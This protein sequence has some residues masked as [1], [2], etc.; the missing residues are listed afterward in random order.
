MTA[1]LC[2]H[3]YFHTRTFQYTFHWCLDGVTAACMHFVNRAVPVRFR[4]MAPT[5]RMMK[6][7]RNFSP[8]NDEPGKHQV[9]KTGRATC[10]SCSFFA[11]P[12]CAKLWLWMPVDRDHSS[13]P[14]IPGVQGT[15][16][17]YFLQVTKRA[18]L[19]QLNRTVRNG[20]TSVSP[21]LFPQTHLR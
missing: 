14:S 7:S 2:R 20:D 12:T 6:W 19:F 10:R 16:I 1:H 13:T 21:F 15:G 3:F 9:V 11:V 5:K 8:G 18:G 17:R 4:F